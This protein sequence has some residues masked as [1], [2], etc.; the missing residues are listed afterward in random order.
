MGNL[1]KAPIDILVNAVSADEFGLFFSPKTGKM[2]FHIKK[3]G[4]IIPGRTLTAAQLANICPSAYDDLATGFTN[5]AAALPLAVKS[6]SKKSTTAGTARVYK[7]TPKL[8]ACAAGKEITLVVSTIPRLLGTAEF[9]DQM[10]LPR[11]YVIRTDDLSAATIA[12]FI[13]AMTALINADTYRAVTATDSTTTLDLAAKSTDNSFT[14][15]MFVTDLTSEAITSAMTSGSETTAHVYPKLTRAEIK[16]IFGIRE[17]AQYGANY[18]AAIDADY[19]RFKILFSNGE[20]YDNVSANGIIATETEVNLYMPTAEIT[21]AYLPIL[22][23]DPLTGTAATWDALTKGMYT[24]PVTL[25]SGGLTVQEYM[26]I[27]F[28]E[29]SSLT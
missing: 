17:G 1:V 3:V 8:A 4:V 2:N 7:I 12:A 19:T 26:E 10:V 9:K 28:A 27:A 18:N 6:V 20:H 22:V 16:Q 24:G 13:T 21:K 5:T 14:A 25:G 23:Y 29:G 15:E 11:Y